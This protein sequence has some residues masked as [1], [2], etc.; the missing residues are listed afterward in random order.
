MEKNSHFNT[1]TKIAISKHGDAIQQRKRDIK[2][3]RN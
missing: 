3:N 1:D 2:K